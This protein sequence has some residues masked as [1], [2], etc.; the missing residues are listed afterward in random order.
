MITGVFF[1]LGGEFLSVVVAVF[2]RVAA[3]GPR[4]TG[5]MASSGVASS[6][7]TG[8][9]TGLTMTTVCVVGWTTITWLVVRIEWSRGTVAETWTTGE[10]RE[11]LEVV[12]YVV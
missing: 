10:G 5:E 11:K 3:A 6:S 9:M 1:G 12:A 2:S 4:S 8:T 7:T